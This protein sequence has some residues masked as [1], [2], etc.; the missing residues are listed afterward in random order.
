M[1]TGCGRSRGAGSSPLGAK[2]PLPPQEVLASASS[3]GVVA[4]RQ[5]RVPRFAVSRTA[6]LVSHSI[7]F[8]C[9]YRAPEYAAMDRAH[10]PLCAAVWLIGRP[11]DCVPG[12]PRYAAVPLL[13]VEPGSGS[14]DRAR[15]LS[16]R[17]QV[18]PW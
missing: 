16:E 1:L 7:R 6:A 13:P 12:A 18:H 10:S 11:R 9:R 2:I 15:L 4:L 5:L 3:E 17:L 14:V 8:R